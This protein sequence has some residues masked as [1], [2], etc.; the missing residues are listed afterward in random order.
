MPLY[1]STLVQLNR[2]ILYSNTLVK[3]LWLT[4]TFQITYKSDQF[5]FKYDADPAGTQTIYLQPEWIKR[6]EDVYL[7]APEH[8]I[9]L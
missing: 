9:R 5:F 7:H 3:Q 4:V 8:L 1:T 2:K 6:L